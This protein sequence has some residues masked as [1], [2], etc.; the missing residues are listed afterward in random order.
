MYF[1]SVLSEAVR[2]SLLTA[3]SAVPPLYRGCERVSGAVKS[4]KD[5]RK[6]QQEWQG[7]CYSG[8]GE[9]TSV[10]VRVYVGKVGAAGLWLGVDP[11]VQCP[12]VTP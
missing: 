10:L 9:D 4:S 6:M 3:W 2:A 7:L 12:G 5:N 11:R 1:F 8:A